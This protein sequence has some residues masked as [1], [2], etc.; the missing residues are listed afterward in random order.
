MR[1]IQEFLE[2]DNGKFSQQ[3]LLNALIVLAFIVNW[4]VILFVFK[5]DYH[6]D[7][8]IIALI[9]GLMGIK[10]YQKKN[11]QTVNRAKD[12]SDDFNNFDETV[13]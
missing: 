2:E 1:R 3:R 13:G 5:Q 6:P 7:Y 12:P 10:A 11:E 8:S 4:M 9:M